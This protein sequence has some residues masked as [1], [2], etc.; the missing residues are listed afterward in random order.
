MSLNLVI[1]ALTPDHGKDIIKFF[2]KLGYNTTV[3]TGS[4][5]KEGNYNKR[6]YG[7]IKGKFGCYKKIDISNSVQL[8]KLDRA[9]EIF[10]KELNNNSTMETP[11]KK[12][13]GPQPGS[14]RNQ[15]QVI[16]E[17]KITKVDQRLGGERGKSV[18]SIQYI[19]TEV[20]IGSINS[21]P[22]SITSQ[23]PV[24]SIKKLGE[25]FN[26]LKTDKEQV[27]HPA[28]YNNY[29]IEAIEMLIGIFGLEKTIDFCI[30]TAMKYRLRLGLKDDFNQDLAKEKWYLDKAKELEERWKAIGGLNKTR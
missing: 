3:F 5:C 22:V 25:V 19:P 11:A 2:Q 14:K 8:L 7:V 1:E 30:M 13:R 28:H 12:K 17:E 24:Q 18:Q 16:L 6:F 15:K 20:G 10:K 23:S 21:I 9:I 26:S 29:P 4:N 27:N